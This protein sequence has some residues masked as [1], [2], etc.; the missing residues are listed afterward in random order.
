VTEK[1]G[2]LQVDFGWRRSKALWHIEHPVQ[3]HF[4]VLG[5][6]VVRLALAAFLGIVWRGAHLPVAIQPVDVRRALFLWDEVWGKSRLALEA[7]RFNL[8]GVSKLP[9]RLEDS[10][11]QFVRLPRIEA[12]A[13]E[14]GEIAAGRGF[15]DLELSSDFAQVARA[16]AIAA[17]DL[18]DA[19]PAQ[20]CAQLPSKVVARSAGGSENRFVVRNSLRPKLP[21]NPALH[22]ITSLHAYT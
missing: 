11:L 3:E 1:P 8:V 22:Q 4:H 5:H 9:L 19:Q 21:P 16:C 12:V 7:R 14:F 15:A 2:D 20:L 17:K 10:I 6:V 13:A 18:S